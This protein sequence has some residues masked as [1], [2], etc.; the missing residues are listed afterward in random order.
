M[1]NWSYGELI[2]AWKLGLSGETWIFKFKIIQIIQ[3][4]QKMLD[5]KNIKALKDQLLR[6]I[7][8]FIH[9]FKLAVA[10]VFLC[11]NAV[12]AI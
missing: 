2:Y 1:I 5:D 6:I 11:Q 12:E 7:L 9:A 10:I 8:C 3:I 4:I